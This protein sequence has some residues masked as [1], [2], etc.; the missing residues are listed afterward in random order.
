M[1]HLKIFGCLCYSLVIDVKR[2][3]M[4]RT[5]LGIF[6]GYSSCKKG[7]RIFYPFT[8]KVFESKDIKFNKEALWNWEATEAK[9]VEQ[10]QVELNVQTDKVQNQY[11]DCFDDLPV[12]GIKPISKVIGV[13]WIYKT[14]LNADG[15]INRLKDRLV[16]KGFSQQYGVNYVET[17][18]G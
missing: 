3:K 1:S 18:L 6:V 5:Q 16:T 13:K 4:E 11:A 2:N 9:M 10:S 7:Y 15:S 12:R 17:F 14:K 8:N